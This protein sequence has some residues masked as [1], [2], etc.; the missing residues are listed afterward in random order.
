[1]IE[2]DIY[3][4]F[5][6]VVRVDSD[7]ETSIP[8]RHETMSSLP[9]LPPRNEMKKPS[10]PSLP[11]L[12]PRN[13][14]TSSSPKMT[15]RAPQPSKQLPLSTK[16]PPE[17]EVEDEEEE[18][19]EDIAPQ[20][21]NREKQELY[22]DIVPQVASREEQELYEDIVPQVA[23]K[24]KQEDLCE[25]YTEM[26]LGEGPTEEY[27]MMERDE[28]VEEQEMY[29]EVDSEMP[30]HAVR[31]GAIV[32]NSPKLP[33]KGNHSPHTTQKGVFFSNSPSLHPKGTQHNTKGAKI[34]KPP[35]PA[36]YISKKGKLKYKA[37][38]KSSPYEQ[39]CKVEGPNLCTY[40]SEMSKM[41]SE[42]IRLSEHDLLFG[43][44]SGEQF[45]FSLTKG[46]AVH[47]FTLGSKDELGGWVSVL[48]TATKSAALQ[49]PP[50]ELQVYVAAEDHTAENAEQL[51]F[52]RG[53][54]I[55]VI[56]QETSGWWVGQLG[57][58]SDQFT[59]RIGKFPISKVMVAE[60]L[61]I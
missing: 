57:S 22:E 55:R 12:P 9:S 8:S 25:E 7:S 2:E 5:D 60:D 29:C 28:E 54:F 26:T 44:S 42:K 4:A 58:S 19:Y 6:E 52:S 23:S 11:T 3:E 51:S 16:A 20:V 21:A 61:Y 33:P 14:L 37:P 49:L 17:V 47:N 48:R 53:V 24:E 39:W 46:D 31:K 43:P 36:S 38:K 40:K 32:T 41:A 15:H 56:A 1:M 35:P 45:V 18:L 34:Q 50:G 59:G 10:E 27:V 30:P 13:S